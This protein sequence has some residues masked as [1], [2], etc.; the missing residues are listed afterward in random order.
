MQ[1]LTLDLDLVEEIHRTLTFGPGDGTVSFSLEDNE[2]SLIFSD[3]CPHVGC[4]TAEERAVSKGG[5]DNACRLML[6][7]GRLLQDIKYISDGTVR[8]EDPTGPSVCL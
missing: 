7:H 4:T 6:R 8:P 3:M 1:Q 2:K 5:F